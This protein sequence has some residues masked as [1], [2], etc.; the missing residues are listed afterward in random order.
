MMVRI[1]DRLRKP[2]PA[3]PARRQGGED[4]DGPKTPKVERPSPNDLL[5]RMKR[6]DPDQ[7]RRYRQR[8]GQ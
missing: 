3:E 4:G 1:E 7:A 8:S 2:A 5:K 6:V